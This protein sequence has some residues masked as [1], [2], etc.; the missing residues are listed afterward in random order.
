MSAA[1]ADDYAVDIVQELRKLPAE[2]EWVE[3][4]ENNEDPQKIGEYVSAVS[5]SAALAGR[6]RGYL[7]W[8]IEDGTHDVVGTSVSLSTKKVGGEVFEN[9]LLR[10][11]HPK[12]GFEFK[13]VT[14]EGERV[15]LLAVERAF[16]NP[17]RFQSEAYVRVGSSL[18]KLK[19][20]PAKERALWRALDETP[21]ERMIAAERVGE[22]DVVQLLDYPSYFDLL[23]LPLP[24]GRSAILKA[25]EGDDLIDRNDAGSWDVTNLGAVLFARQLSA[26][27]GL[28]RKSVR[29]IE[30]K[31]RTRIETVREREGTM[32]YA[33]GFE[34]LIGYVNSRL[35]SNEVIGQALREEVPMYPELAVRELVA[36]A[37]IHQDFSETGN[38]PTV[39]LFEDRVEVTNPGKPIVEPDLFLNTPPKS[40]NEALASLMRR[41]RMCEERG[42]GIDKVVSEIERYQLPAP[43]FEAPGNNTRVVLLSPRPLTKMDK[44]D[45]IRAC[46]LHACLMYAQ[47]DYLTNSSLRER[48]GINPRNAATASR[49]INEAVEAE[50][51]R[52]Y[53]EGAAKR[54]MKYVPFWA[55]PA[56]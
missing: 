20:A 39:E 26:F 45:R 7:V 5:N 44:E 12:I 11:L 53:D 49:L 27:S 25:F 17:V 29:V 38:G 16:K 10:M 8:G 36:N 30:Y 42:T 34:G 19:D 31:G 6:P 33:S 15:V 32:G 50:A 14:V 41:M 48:F 4:K 56:I 18:K 43:I 35:P 23:K 28:R 47:R 54:L 13:E 55:V 52:P 24:E 40:R 9:W 1:L 22:E 2:A 37:L 21:F 3:F 46:Y 51:I